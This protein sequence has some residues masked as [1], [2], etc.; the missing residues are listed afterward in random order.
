MRITDFTDMTDAGGE[1]DGQ[2]F[3][4]QRHYGLGFLR[5]Q[6]G[7]NGSAELSALIVPC[8]VEPTS[9]AACRHW[10][11]PHFHSFHV[12]QSLEAAAMRSRSLR[13][14]LA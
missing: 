6:A 12:E 10:S 14:L 9:S 7:A 3:L 13:V 2:A 11:G 4:A 1:R 8:Q 5:C